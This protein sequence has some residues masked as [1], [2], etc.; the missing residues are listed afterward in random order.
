[1]ISAVCQGLLSCGHHFG[2]REDPGDKVGR[3]PLNI[4]ARPFVSYKKHFL[5]SLV[6]SDLTN[7]HQYVKFF[8]CLTRHCI[9]SENARLGDWEFF[10]TRLK[11]N[12]S[13]LRQPGAIRAHPCL[14]EILA[15]D[16]HTTSPPPHS[17]RASSKASHYQHW[18]DDYLLGP[19]FI[20]FST[21]IRNIR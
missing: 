13:R 11:L 15:R 14:F 10:L 9:R 5:W 18:L 21:Y 20:W 4:D 6:N 1:M 8:A 12:V 17:K 3:T 2:K 16:I 7:Q 19:I